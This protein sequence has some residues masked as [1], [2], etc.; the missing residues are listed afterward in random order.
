MKHAAV[1]LSCALLSPLVLAA[2][3]REPQVRATNASVEEVAN[4][5]ADARGSEDLVRPGK[6]E[7]KVQIEEFSV[8]G[9]P[10][11]AAA[12]MNG[13][14]NRVHVT[15]SCLTPEEAK[16][17]K[18]KFFAGANKNC[19]YDHFTMGGGK[20]DAVMKCTGNGM[21]QVM[22]MQGTYGPDDYQMQMSMQAQGGP[23]PADAL[24][25]ATSL[26]ATSG[27]DDR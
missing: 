7:S 11:S 26:S 1:L 18:E 2:C 22:T 14:Q 16:R 4:K 15:E 19:R 20:I 13:L 6:W 9:A 8:P 25:S 24:V 12:A 23:G 27:E 10:P 21:A 3:N 5:V 17:P